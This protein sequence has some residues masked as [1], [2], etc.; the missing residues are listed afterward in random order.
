MYKISKLQGD[1]IWEKENNSIFYW[2]WRRLLVLFSKVVLTTIIV[3]GCESLHAQSQPKFRNFTVNDGLEIN[4]VQSIVQDAHGFLWFDNSVSLTRFDGYEFKIYRHSMDDSLAQ[5]GPG[6][7]GVLLNDQANNIWVSGFE[8]SGGGALVGNGKLLKY[9]ADRDGFVAYTPH[10]DSYITCLA[11]DPD[12]SVIWLGTGR[13]LYS[14][15]TKTEK[16]YPYRVLNKGKAGSL[17]LNGRIHGIVCKGRYLQLFTNFGLWFFDKKEK[18][19]TRPAVNQSDSLLFL[20]GRLGGDSKAVVNWERRIIALVDSLLSVRKVIAFPES[21]LNAYMLDIDDRGI[22]YAC[23]RDALVAKFGSRLLRYDPDRESLDTLLTDNLSLNVMLD[24][25]QNV[26]IYNT[27]GAWMY[28]PSEVRYET[29]KTKSSLS[30]RVNELRGEKQ[31]RF[32][33]GSPNQLDILTFRSGKLEEESFSFSGMNDRFTVFNFAWQG[34]KYFWTG[35]WGRGV[36]GFPIDH[37]NSTLAKEGIVIYDTIR[38]NVNSI[39]EQFVWGGIYEDKDGNIWTGTYSAG[40]N[41]IN[42]RIQYGMEGSIERFLHR[43]ADTTSISS[44]HIEKMIPGR[45]GELWIGTPVGL[46][47]FRDGKFYHPLKGYSV[48]ALFM[49]SNEDLYVGTPREIFLARKSDE[50]RKFARVSAAG[51]FN[52]SE[53]DLGRLWMATPKGLALFDPTKQITIAFGEREGLQY[54][55][56]V[57]IL[58]DGRVGFF[59]QRDYISVLD[60]HSFTINEK[61]VRPTITRLLVNHKDAVVSGHPYSESDFVIPMGTAAMKELEL[62]YRHNNF[63]FEFSAMEMTAP[64]KNL[65]RHM[66]EGFDKDWI[67]TTSKDRTATYTNLPP[68]T[69]TF[70]VKASNHH[71]VWSDNE[72]TL[73]VMILP[74]P[75]RTWWAYTGYSLL[76]IGLLLLARRSIVQ[77]ERLKASLSLEKVER[78]KEH[79]ELEKAKEVD[80]VKTS[81][82]TNISHEFRTPLTLIKGPVDAMLD[83]FKDDPE[84]VKRLKLVQRNSELL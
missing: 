50:Y 11:M 55:G 4:I 44:N 18:S 21:F 33:V 26:W 73:K 25:D 2:C 1:V 36:I 39:S 45:Q 48:V 54:M 56:G 27:N 69:Y 28:L 10:V 59:S 67:E 17:E 74:P 63:M 53:D 71:G 42:R 24:R 61:G 34:A 23:V 20:T 57:H 78:E 31:K 12:S 38:G 62:D 22:L 37:K 70:R 83:R 72:R 41:K 15:N 77:R 76:A 5:L 46:D 47:M 19:F 64:E 43:P 51:L 81:F 3:V 49:S 30:G 52:A 66:L 9:D 13:G 29:I 80:R 68:G 60:P 35:T 58:P 82:F 6:F 79:F 75:W 14:F 84:A 40:L 65:Y 16:T 8:L 32:V 7:T